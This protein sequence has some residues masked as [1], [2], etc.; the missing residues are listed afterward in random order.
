MLSANMEVEKIFR[1]GMKRENIVILKIIL[2]LISTL[3]NIY[4]NIKNMYECIYDSAK[5]DNSIKGDF[6][7]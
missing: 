5:K 4:T 3:Q 1:S 2:K 6:N 7:E